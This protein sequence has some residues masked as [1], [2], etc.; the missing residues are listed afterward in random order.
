VLCYLRFMGE[1]LVAGALEAL[2]AMAHKHL[3]RGFA[4]PFLVSFHPELLS[5]RIDAALFS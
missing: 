5:L 2:S 1:S 3:E 4:S